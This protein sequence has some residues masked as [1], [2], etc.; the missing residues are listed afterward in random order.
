MGG[1]GASDG[2]W[3]LQALKNR[4]MEEPGREANFERNELAIFLQFPKRNDS[5]LFVIPMFLDDYHCV[6]I[7]DYIIYKDDY[8]IYKDGY[9]IIYKDDYII[10]KDDYIDDIDDWWRFYRWLFYHAYINVWYR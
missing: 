9:I 3:S 6:Y 4:G 10:Y 5:D 1:E 8:I 7:D 2:D